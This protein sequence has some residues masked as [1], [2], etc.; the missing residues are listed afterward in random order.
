MISDVQIKE[1]VAGCIDFQL[2]W[3]AKFKKANNPLHLE[4]KKFIDQNN[5]G[6]KNKMKLWVI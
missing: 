3:N 6:W 5:I 4:L 2:F 1:I